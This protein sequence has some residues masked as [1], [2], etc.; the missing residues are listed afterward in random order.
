MVY[1]FSLP[2]RRQSILEVLDDGSV[3]KYGRDDLYDV[4]LAIKP[5]GLIKACKWGAMF[6][7]QNADI[8]GSTHPLHRRVEINRNRSRPCLL[9][10]C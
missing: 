6:V 2:P 7:S 9:Q 10:L 8:F 3:E 4:F 5:F 1:V